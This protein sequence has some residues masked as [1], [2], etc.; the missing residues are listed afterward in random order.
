MRRIFIITLLAIITTTIASAQVKGKR[1]RPTAARPESAEQQLRKMERE[2]FDALERKD[3]IVL[4]R[5][6]ADDFISINHDGKVVNKAEM[7]KNAQSGGV[8]V[9]SI[10]AEDFLSRVYGN[11]A[12][13]T[14]RSTYFK[15]GNMVGDVRHTQ[16]WAKRQGRWQAV[17]WQATNVASQGA[18]LS[19]AGE[20]VSASGLKYVDLVVGKGESPKPGQTIIVHYTGTLEDGTQF[21]SS[22]GGEPISFQIGV[23]RVIKGW[24]EGVMSMKVG[25]KRKLIIPPHLGYGARGAGGAVPPNATLIFEVELLGVK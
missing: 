19:A 20:V 6:L 25:G 5:I 10:K 24:D 7:L 18:S 9:D 2:F 4:G 21:D 15:S 1:P 23:G 16:V 13:V 14:G 8:V 22:I 3:V 17:S 11:M 12:V